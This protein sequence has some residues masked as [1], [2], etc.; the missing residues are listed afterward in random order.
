[1]IL[2]FEKKIQNGL[3]KKIEFFKTVNSQKKNSKISGI[4]S[5][6]NGINVAHP[7]WFVRSKTGKKCIFL[8]FLPV[9]DLLSDSLMTIS[10]KPQFAS[11]YPTDQRTNP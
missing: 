4:G 9:L 11:I 6:V 5:W 10:V 8:C 2:F 3:L 7:I 1:L